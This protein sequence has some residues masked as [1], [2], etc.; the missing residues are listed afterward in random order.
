MARGNQANSGGRGKGNQNA[1]KH[2]KGDERRDNPQHSGPT[3]PGGS[4]RGNSGSDSNAEQK[5]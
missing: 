5:D 4:G 1:A 2:E 3:R